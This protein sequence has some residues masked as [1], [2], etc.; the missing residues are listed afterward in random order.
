MNRITLRTY[1]Y[2]GDGF[3]DITLAIV[4]QINMHK[5]QKSPV[6][7]SHQK[8]NYFP[9]NA[10]DDTPPKLTYDTLKTAVLSACGTL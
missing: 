5:Y 4:L 9:D 8:K 2:I 7:N 1:I 10:A 3:T 6:M